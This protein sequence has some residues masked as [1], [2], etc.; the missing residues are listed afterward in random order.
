[1]TQWKLIASISQELKP[2][3]RGFGFPS[4]SMS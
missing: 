4:E 1:V 3:K 2:S